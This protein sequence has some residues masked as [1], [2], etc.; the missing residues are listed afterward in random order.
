MKINE[1]NNEL[2]HKI[3]QALTSAKNV[4]RVEYTVNDIANMLA[5]FVAINNMEAMSDEIVSGIRK[6]NYQIPKM[7]DNLVFGTVTYSGVRLETR[8]VDFEANFVPE[9]TTD[10][11]GKQIN[12]FSDVRVLSVFEMSRLSDRIYGGFKKAADMVS[13]S[14]KAGEFQSL[15]SIMGQVAVN[16]NFCVNS[17]V[18]KQY[19]IFLNVELFTGGHVSYEQAIEAWTDSFRDYK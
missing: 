2:A 15:D 14:T 12:N 10:E 11:R 13:I 1:F 4:S 3:Y 16:E 7:F 9:V 6:D 5:T 17:F 18:L 19:P 8:L